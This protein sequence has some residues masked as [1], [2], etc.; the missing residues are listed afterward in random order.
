MATALATACIWTVLAP[1]RFQLLLLRRLSPGS[2]WIAFVLSSF[3]PPLFL[4]HT[5]GGSTH[6]SPYTF[7][8][9]RL[10]IFCFIYLLYQSS[11]PVVDTVRPGP[12]GFSK[13]YAAF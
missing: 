13:A 6:P 1:T 12:I 8:L 5:G 4:R 10:Y 11:P 2:N 9:I 3:L 7:L